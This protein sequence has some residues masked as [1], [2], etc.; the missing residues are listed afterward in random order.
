MPVIR[1]N[2]RVLMQKLRILPDLG[3][4]NENGNLFDIAYG[5]PQDSLK[6]AAYDHELLKRYPIKTLRQGAS[7]SIT[8][9][10]AKNQKNAR[11]TQQNQRN[12][13]RILQVQPDGQRD[14]GWNPFYC[15]EI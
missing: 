6:R 2:Y 1:E 9:F 13:Y 15:G 7:R 4:S 12:Y 3:D 14:F 11:F 5:H 8:N 10:E